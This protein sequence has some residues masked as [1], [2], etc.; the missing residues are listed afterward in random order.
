M[1]QQVPR[2]GSSISLTIHSLDAI[3]GWVFHHNWEKIKA[4]V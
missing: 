1:A 2:A 3:R 4:V